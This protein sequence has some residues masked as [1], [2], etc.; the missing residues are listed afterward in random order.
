MYCDVSMYCVMYYVPLHDRR[1]GDTK[2]YL[3]G[4]RVVHILFFFRVLRFKIM[5]GFFIFRPN[6]LESE[7]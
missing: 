1:Q 6:S 2:Y 7:L 3:I 5:D 4:N